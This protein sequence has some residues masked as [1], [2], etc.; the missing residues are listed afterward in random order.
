MV[1]FSDMDVEFSDLA[2]TWKGK[3]SAEIQEKSVEKV[4]KFKKIIRNMKTCDLHLDICRYFYYSLLLNL[5]HL[6][7]DKRFYQIYFSNYVCNSFPYHILFHHFVFS[8]MVNPDFET[9]KYT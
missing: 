2:I 6:S 7:A 4:F 3:E 9:F 8:F 1:F 5:L